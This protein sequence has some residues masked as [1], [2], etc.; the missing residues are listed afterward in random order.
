M[1]PAKLR[2]TLTVGLMPITLV[3]LISGLLSVTSA[4]ALYVAHVL[5]ASPM[6]GVATVEGNVG[7]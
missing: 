3:G 1:S 4:G 7:R 2:G 5:R 6:V